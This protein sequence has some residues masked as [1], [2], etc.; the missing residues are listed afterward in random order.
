[1]TC[2]DVSAVYEEVSNTGTY[3]NNFLGGEG[4]RGRTAG[5][6]LNWQAK[7]ENVTVFEILPTADLIFVFVKFLVVFNES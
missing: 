5:N 2:L 6:F 1:M 3:R 4:E 7:K